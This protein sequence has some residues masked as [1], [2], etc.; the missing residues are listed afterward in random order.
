MLASQLQ[1]LLRELALQQGNRTTTK[2]ASAAT[3]AAAAVT[4]LVHMRNFAAVQ[5]C[6]TRK[7]IQACI[8]GFLEGAQL[9]ETENDMGAVVYQRKAPAA[10]KKG[11]KS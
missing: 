10:A 3:S 5:D 1:P 2:V 11:G 9:E 8:D 7:D 6:L 4:L